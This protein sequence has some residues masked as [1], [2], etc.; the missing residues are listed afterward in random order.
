MRLPSTMI[1]IVVNIDDGL[2]VAAIIPPLNDLPL[3]VSL[4]DRRIGAARCWK[5]TRSRHFSFLWRKTIIGLYAR[6]YNIPP[7]ECLPHG[8][9]RYPPRGD[10]GGSPARQD[11]QGPGRA[12][13]GHGA[14]RART[15]CRRFQEQKRKGSAAQLAGSLSQGTHPH[16]GRSGICRHV[17]A[18]A[19]Y[20][21]FAAKVHVPD[22]SLSR[23]SAARN[24]PNT[25]PFLRK[26]FAEIAG[27]DLP[28]S[29]LL[30]VDDIVALLNR[31]DLATVLRDF[32][33]GQDDKDP[34][35]HF[36]E[37]FL[38]GLR[39]AHATTPRRLLHA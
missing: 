20:G 16:P 2:S 38:D 34:V 11:R 7:R 10:S 27:G 23:V 30:A 1:V 24:L 6:N 15:D 28:D 12:F 13:G 37:T 25:E 33:K 5:I 3:L 17:R 18:T 31:V 29:I 32:G 19:A 9:C 22:K 8:R 35:V 36:Y 14:D 26:F 39:A 21:Y 4:L